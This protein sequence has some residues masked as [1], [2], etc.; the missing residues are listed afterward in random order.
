MEKCI[1]TVATTG[2]WPKKENNPN[3]PMTPREIAEEVNACWKAGAAIAHLHMRDDQGNGTM[4]TEKFRE[5]VGL[6]KEMKCDIILN[7]TTSGDLQA[8]E[9]TRMAH[10]IELKPEM[11]SYDCG[12]MNWMHNSLF[13]NPPAFLEKLGLVMQENGVKPEIEAF[14]ASFIYNAMYYQKKGI[15]K[16][17]LH[18]Q[19]CLGAAGGSAATVENLVY[20]KGLIPQDATWSAFGVGAGHMPILL[21]SVALG[22]HIRIGME[23]N[24]MYAKN[25]LAA[26]NV[27]FVERAVRIIKEANRTV[28][29]S[30]DARQILS[31]KK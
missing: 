25:R 20:L 2:A 19:F 23:D 26:S 6:I 22:G 24:V 18:F 4:S 12:S 30:D 17:P 15:L 8:T 28:A 27:E 7:C 5:T 10:L 3:V 11:A 31:L 29:T 13:L 21:A 9:V 16:G 14:D 1:I